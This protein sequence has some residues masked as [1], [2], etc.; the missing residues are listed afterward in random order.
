M[1]ST[2]KEYVYKTFQN[3]DLSR[4]LKSLISKFGLDNGEIQITY[5]FLVDG[6][7]DQKPLTWDEVDLITSFKNDNLDFTF[8]SRDGGFISFYS[9][10]IWDLNGKENILRILVMF[11]D[12]EKLK[13]TFAF[14]ENELELK[15]YDE[16]DHESTTDSSDDSRMVKNDNVTIVNGSNGIERMKKEHKESFG[17]LKLYLDNI[18]QITQLFID[19]FPKYEIE[20]DKYKI[21]SNDIGIVKNSL[22]NI[23]E[24][25]RDEL[26]KKFI[27]R[28]YE[29]DYYYSLWLMITDS[30]AL[31]VLKD[32]EDF[33]NLGLAYHISGILSNTENK[34]LNKLSNISNFMLI[35][36]LIA[37][38]SILLSV[39]V[40]LFAKIKVINSNVANIISSILIL[41]P[42]LFALI[43][44]F[45][46][47]P[48]NKIYLNYNEKG[49]FFQRNRDKILVTGGVGLFVAIIN[50]V[51]NHI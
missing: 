19:N 11:N 48:K 40:L 23:R 24:D 5:H 49:S 4:A 17:S 18:I 10:N 33:K 8:P 20:I 46:S 6:I 14:L 36:V 12:I 26:P 21:A 1:A 50:Y 31:I 30:T 41:S 25:L 7:R 44:S 37:S 35:L 13:N 45:F 9:D 38:F 43:V 42:F 16:N 47:S 15:K 32:D 34:L 28:G 39:I 27:L 2:S 51:L 29:S 3:G 22:E